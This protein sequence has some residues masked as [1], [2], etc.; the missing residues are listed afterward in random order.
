VLTD[1]ERA[2]SVFIAFIK[3]ERAKEQRVKRPEHV[4][5]RGEEALT[6]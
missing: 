4:P 5:D 6:R 3:E 1:R 2:A